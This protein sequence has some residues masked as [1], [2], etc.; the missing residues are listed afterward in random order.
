MH[1]TDLAYKFCYVM[2]V[3]ALIVTFCVVTKRAIAHVWPVI[4]SFVDAKVF[5]CVCCP[6][7]RSINDCRL[8]LVVYTW[9]NTF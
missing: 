7:N 5:M 8:Y 6:Q 1:M 4:E 9:K 2:H 3:L